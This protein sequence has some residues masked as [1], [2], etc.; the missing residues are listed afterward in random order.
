MSWDCGHKSYQLGTAIVMP[1]SS[2]QETDRVELAQVAIAIPL[3]CT[4]CGRIDLI[5]PNI[6]PERKVEEWKDMY[7]A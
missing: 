3:L 6:E 1:V 2:A 4:V 7:R 5:R